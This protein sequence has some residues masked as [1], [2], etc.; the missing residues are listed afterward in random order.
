MLDKGG[1]HIESVKALPHR[2]DFARGDSSAGAVG[3]PTAI[4]VEVRDQL[5]GSR[6]KYKY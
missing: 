5:L 2:G 4:S 6:A 3:E 1:S